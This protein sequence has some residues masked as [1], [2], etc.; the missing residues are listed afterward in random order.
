MECQHFLADEN[1]NCIDCGQPV[2]GLPQISPEDLE[3]IKKY[4]GMAHPIV[5]KVAPKEDLM[6][7]I[8]LADDTIREYEVQL[9]VLQD[10]NLPG[11][12]KIQIIG[13]TIFRPTWEEIWNKITL[14]SYHGALMM[15]Y[16]SSLTRWDEFLKDSMQLMREQGLSHRPQIIFPSFAE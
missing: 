11:Q 8:E 1:G 9:L 14:R 12:P 16:H 4:S 13:N 7:I 2:E 6:G 10:P 3:L 15:G 5:I